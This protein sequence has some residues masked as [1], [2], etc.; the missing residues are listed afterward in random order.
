MTKKFKRAL[1]IQ[2]LM[3][4]IKNL[5]INILHPYCVYLNEATVLNWQKKVHGFV[6][7][8][9]QFPCFLKLCKG[10]TSTCKCN[11]SIFF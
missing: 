10:K 4:E 5:N 9:I 2:T 11:M 6:F 1:N 8:S 3:F 7:K